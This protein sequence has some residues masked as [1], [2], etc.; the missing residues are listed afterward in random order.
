MFQ[1][2]RIRKNVSSTV[3]AIKSVIQQIITNFTPKFISFYN[4][5]ADLIPNI[6]ND[7]E[8]DLLLEQYKIKSQHYEIASKFDIYKNLSVNT[9]FNHD[10]YSDYLEVCDYRLINNDYK[11]FLSKIYKNKTIHIKGPKLKTN[12]ALDELFHIKD[13]L[14]FELGKKYVTGSTLINKHYFFNNHWQ[15]SLQKN[16]RLLYKISSRSKQLKSKMKLVLI[17]LPKLNKFIHVCYKNK[18]LFK[19]KK[20]PTDDPKNPLYRGFDNDWLSLK[21][22]EPF[23]KK[24]KINSSLNEKLTKS[25]ISKSKHN[26]TIKSIVKLQKIAIK[27]NNSKLYNLANSY[28]KKLFTKDSVLVQITSLKKKKFK[29]FI[30]LNKQLRIGWNNNIWIYNKL[31]YNIQTAGTLTHYS[32]KS[33]LTAM[34]IKKKLK[35]SN[36][37]IKN[38]KIFVLANKFF[39]IK[40]FKKL[41]KKKLKNTFS[42]KLKKSLYLFYKFLKKTNQLTN[43]NYYLNNSKTT[44]ITFYNTYN[45]LFSKAPIYSLS[46]RFNKKINIQNNLNILGFFKNFQVKVPNVYKSLNK[47]NYSLTI[48]ENNNLPTQVQNSLKH[49]LIFL[50]K[51]N[52][53]KDTTSLFK[54][55]SFLKHIIKNFYLYPEQ[56]CYSLKHMITQQLN[57]DRFINKKYPQVKK[58]NLKNIKLTI[59]SLVSILKKKLKKLSKAYWVYKNYNKKFKKIK[60]LITLTS[61]LINIKK[62]NSTTIKS[63]RLLSLYTYIISKVN[64]E[65][66][67]FVNLNI[68]INKN[69]LLKKQSYQKAIGYYKLVS[70]YTK[71]L[72]KNSMLGIVDFNEITKF[73][74]FVKLNKLKLNSSKIF[75]YF[76]N[77]NTNLKKKSLLFNFFFKKEL[78]NIIK[79][80]KELQL[81]KLYQRRFKL[82]KLILNGKN[83]YEGISYLEKVSKKRKYFNAA[84]SL[85]SLKK[86]TK[87]IK[88]PKFKN[89]SLAATKTDRSKAWEDKLYKKWIY[90]RYKNVLIDNFKLLK[91]QKFNEV[92]N[93]LLSNKLTKKYF[94]YP[95]SEPVF[96]RKW[97]KVVITDFRLPIILQLL[98]IKSKFKID[99]KL[100]KK[101]QIKLLKKFNLL[102]NYK[103]IYLKKKT[104]LYLKKKKL[105]KTSLRKLAISSL[106]Y[107]KLITKSIREKNLKQ[108][109]KFRQW[110]KKISNKISSK[111]KKKLENT[112]KQN[113]V[114]SV[115]KYRS[116]SIKKES[117]KKKLKKFNILKFQKYCK[118]RFNK[119]TFFLKKKKYFISLLKKKKISEIK[120]AKKKI[121]NSNTSNLYNNLELKK[122]IASKKKKVF[123]GNK[124]TINFKKLIL[125]IKYNIKKINNTLINVKYLIKLNNFLKFHLKIKKLKI[126]VKPSII[127]KIYPV[128][129]VFSKKNLKKTKIIKKIK[130]K[131]TVLKWKTNIIS[132]VKLVNIKKI[133]ISK[134]SK[135]AKVSLTNKIKKKTWL[136]KKLKLKKL[137]LKKNKNKKKNVYK[138]QKLIYK[139]QRGSVKIQKKQQLWLNRKLLSKKQRNLTNIVLLNKNKVYTNKRAIE[140]VLKA[141]KIRKKRLYN[142]TKNK[143]IRSPNLILINEKNNKIKAQLIANTAKSKIKIQSLINKNITKKKNIIKNNVK[144]N[145]T[146][147][148]TKKKF[149]KKWTY[150][151]IVLLTVGALKPSIKNNSHTDIIKRFFTKIKNKQPK[152]YKA[153]LIQYENSDRNT[154][155]NSSRAKHT[156]LKLKSQWCP[157][158][159]VKKEI[160]NIKKTKSKISK[161]IKPLIK[162]KIKRTP[163]DNNFK[164]NIKKK[165]TIKTPKNISHLIEAV[166]SFS[167]NFKKNFNYYNKTYPSDSIN[168]FFKKIK[169]YRFLKLFS[170]RNERAAELIKNKKINFIKNYGKAKVLKQ[171]NWIFIKKKILQ[172]KKSQRL[173]LPKNLQNIKYLFTIIN[174]AKFYNA[175]NTKFLHTGKNKKMYRTNRIKYSLY[176]FMSQSAPEIS[177]FM[178]TLKTINGLIRTRFNNHKCYRLKKLKIISLL[179]KK[180]KLK[181]KLELK[182][183]LRISKLPKLPKLFKPKKRTSWKKL[184]KKNKIKKVK[185]MHYYK[186]LKKIQKKIKLPDRI[187]INE[188]DRN[189]IIKPQHIQLK[190]SFKVKK[191]IYSILVQIKKNNMIK[192]K[193]IINKLKNTISNKKKNSLFMV[194][195]KNYFYKIYNRLYKKNLVISQLKNI[196][197]NSLFKLKINL[198]KKKKF[199]KI[200][201]TNFNLKELIFLNK[202]AKISL[203][204]NKK[205]KNK[206]I[207]KSL[208]KNINNRLSKNINLNSLKYYHQTHK[209]LNRRLTKQISNYAKY[210]LYSN[211]TLQKNTIKNNRFFL[212][213]QVSLNL[214]IHKKIRNVEYLIKVVRK[215]IKKIHKKKWKKIKKKWSNLKRFALKR[216]YLLKK[217]VV[218][219][220]KYNSLHNIP[221]INIKLNIRNFIFLNKPAYESSLLN[222]Y[223]KTINTKTNVDKKNKKTLFFNFR[224]KKLTTY[225][226]ARQLHWKHV[227]H[228][229]L[230]KRK[231][232]KFIKKWVKNINSYW[233]TFKTHCMFKFNFS[234]QFWESFILLYRTVYNKALEYKTVSQLPIHTTFW[235]FLNLQKKLIQ[236]VSLRLN[237]WQE[238]KIKIKKT[239]WME[240]KKN[241]PKFIKKKLFRLYKSLSALHYDYITNCFIMLKNIKQPIHNNLYFINN[242]LLKLHDFKY[243]S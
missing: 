230:N 120:L 179:R 183:Q 141:L 77:P 75:N 23:V 18:K 189:N 36:F 197:Q 209:L 220:T 142:K 83:L 10:I 135:K 82:T 67:N 155:R 80:S 38:L 72:K 68:K 32:Q 151:D 11:F 40:L 149:I 231:Y 140:R 181:K 8:S 210:L 69:N 184:L 176:Q 238:K 44:F 61:L 112:L 89:P 13:K 125:K 195:K 147:P 19:K 79:Y 143:S 102:S 96:N 55:Y 217:S 85:K 24:K 95:F 180:T 54:N 5:I 207:Y 194:I 133:N 113:N 86:K 182:E 173:H 45:P 202:I 94:Y 148:L 164:L 187:N 71:N 87:T 46:N 2:T 226:K 22:L 123:N 139:R 130:K 165:T 121:N 53:L 237:F 206:I 170:D 221:I 162:K 78:I 177:Y 172:K 17:D 203:K 35:N 212:R 204:K 174:K 105:I 163:L 137:K 228:K 224:N 168:F 218:L 56:F 57:T 178:Q 171:K 185:K 91:L 131:T 192:A 234:H 62:L 111:R 103:K 66:K 9:V 104:Y 158:N 84:H 52:I 215:N 188:L 27:S 225:R 6:F 201:S 110:Q 21:K 239:F 43:N 28:R 191:K 64:Y 128:N 25:G 122:K 175:T 152:R 29:H 14:R 115:L 146:T 50:K 49:V 243:K 154:E 100:L 144:L 109:A 41:K 58:N 222:F 138:G 156:L 208:I 211:K 12:V 223:F 90:L 39:K 159:F 118:K 98:S 186:Q 51:N 101:K 199:L 48:K 34:Y 114:V 108:L 93:S 59:K 81:K 26:F 161:Q 16:H 7:E 76:L 157:N 242:K 198:I 116:Q 196:Q 124:L 119:L 232:S 127:S 216:T 214:R 134:A 106:S 236:K 229:K 227:T 1:A 33:L 70:I 213:S 107:R 136:L 31:L 235:W 219:V 153:F 150:N 97:K 63:K 92:K 132:A 160:N 129:Y 205:K 20:K 60:T 126:S 166:S 3:V 73:K 145:K 233:S 42:N 240:Q 47:N 4:F 37:I 193:Y 15:N 99:K 190:N 65:S 169:S 241:L 74:K 30:K 117:I 167:N 88:N 200:K